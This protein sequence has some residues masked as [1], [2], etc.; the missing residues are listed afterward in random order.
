M[1]IEENADQEELLEN[2]GSKTREVDEKSKT[3]I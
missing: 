1:S 2:M 3:P